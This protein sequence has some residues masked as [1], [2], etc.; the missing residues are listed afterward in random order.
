[1]SNV[2]LIPSNEPE[3]LAREYKTDLLETIK[4]STTQIRH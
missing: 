1:M 2:D 4:N 3:K